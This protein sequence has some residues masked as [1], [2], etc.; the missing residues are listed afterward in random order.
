M[1]LEATLRRNPKLIEAAF[2]LHSEGLI[3]PDTYLID[4]D[5][6]L[7]N[8]KEIKKEADKYEIKLYFMTKQFGRNPYISRE[9]MKLGYEGA[10]AVD[11]REAEVLASGGVPLGHIGHLV[12]IPKHK[13]EGV[14]KVKPQY[15]TVYSVE[16]AK[17]VSEAAV[18]LGII[19]KVMIRVIDKGD[20]LYPA[21]YGGFYLEELF[22][23]AKEIIKLPNII[24]SGITTFPCFLYDDKEGFVKE[25]P[26]AYTLQKAKKVLEDELL[27]NIE[28]VNMPSATCSCN[29]SNIAKF[30][31]THGEPGHGILGTTPI[32]AVS[33]QP[34]IPAMVYVSEVS[35]NLGN[36]SFCYGGGHYRRSH[37]SGALVGKSLDSAVKYNVETPQAD[38]IDYYFAL[39][40]TAAVSDTVVMSFRTQ[41]FVTRSKVAIVKGIQGDK[42]ELVG[43]YD[44]QGSFL[45]GGMQIE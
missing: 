16:K 17:E 29:M 14:L 5:M 13:I 11:Y 25:T 45:E 33:D 28:Q 35:H 9:L 36:E 41:V 22:E 21:Q 32:H 2:R 27:I 10:V 15:I 38:S 4:L 40:N 39:D 6:M 30:G 19:Q 18:R 3:E 23:K 31:G 20:M 44:S 26:N 37:M 8:A 43:I 24:L 42:P 34:E 1:F 12:Q 7:K